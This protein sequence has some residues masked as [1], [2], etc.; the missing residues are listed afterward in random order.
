MGKNVE[1][2]LDA[3]GVLGAVLGLVQVQGLS[4]RVSGLVVLAECGVGV[5]DVVEGFCFEEAIVKMAV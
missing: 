3:L 2:L 5:A 1:L 4:P